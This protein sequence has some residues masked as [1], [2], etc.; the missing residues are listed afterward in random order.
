MIFN[1][2][3][4]RARNYPLF[5]LEDVF[6]WFP[7]AERATTLNQLNL[8]TQK[9]YL[10]RIRRGIYKLSDFEIGEPFLLA[11]FIYT[12]SYI[13]LET[14]LNYY[15]II[16]DI[17]FAVTSVT[18]KKTITFRN[19][20]YG[21]FFYSSIKPDLFFGFNSVL[22][23]KK[24]GYNIALPEKAL[25]DYFYLRAK[26]VKPTES[27]IEELRLSFPPDFHWQKFRKWVKLVS[28]KNKNFH[29]LNQILIQKYHAP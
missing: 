20:N 26:K 29:Q 28:P 24:Y 11:S 23:E 5:K 13:S 10:E 2:L 15:S 18:T 1:E 14:A 16:P 9:G 25:F 17:P 21:V 12:P 8:W 6:K 7:G 19:K 3:K 22:A 27:F 4:N